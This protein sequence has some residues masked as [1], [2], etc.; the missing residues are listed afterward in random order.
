VK[1]VG[2]GEVSVNAE[3]SSDRASGSVAR[4][5]LFSNH[6]LNVLLERRGVHYVG[7]RANLKGGGA[8]IGGNDLFIAAHT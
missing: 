7:I 6:D 2:R 3:A 1:A 4:T 8:M 5:G